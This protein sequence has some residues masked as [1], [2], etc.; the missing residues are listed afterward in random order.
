[1]PRALLGLCNVAAEDAAAVGR[2]ALEGDCGPLSLPTKWA[3]SG[4]GV[5]AVLHGADGGLAGMASEGAV[6]ACGLLLQSEAVAS[7]A[8]VSL[9]LAVADRYGVRTGQVRWTL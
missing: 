4:L 1:M 2:A 3:A 6:L 9:S 8:K 5:T 7:A